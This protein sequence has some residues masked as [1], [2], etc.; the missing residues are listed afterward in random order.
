MSVLDD[1]LIRSSTLGGAD[2]VTRAEVTALVKVKPSADDPEQPMAGARVRLHRAADG[3]LAWQGRSGADGSYRASGLEAGTSYVPVAIDLTGTYEAV[4]AGPVLAKEPVRLVPAEMT[5]TVGQPFEQELRLTGL[6]PPV[7][8]IT[9][10]GALPSGVSAS[11]LVLSGAWPTGAVGSYPIIYSVTDAAGEHEA[12]GSIEL[13]LLPL[14][15]S[16][17]APVPTV[18]EEKTKIPDI[19][20]SATGGELPY[21]WACV[22]DLPTGVTFN[23][24]TQVLSGTPTI[25]DE[26]FDA[27]ISVTDVRGASKQIR[28]NGAVLSWLDGVT[29]YIR[30]TGDA[31]DTSF[32]DDGP[33]ARAIS[34]S[35]TITAVT[36]ADAPSGLAL[37]GFVGGTSHLY[38]SAVAAD[39]MRAGAFQLDFGIRNTAAIA[40]TDG[41]YTVLS[42]AENLSGRVYEWNIGTDKDAIHFYYGTRGAGQAHVRFIYPGG[43]DLSS[44][45]GTRHAMSIGRDA[46]GRWGAW[47]DGVRCAQYEASSYSGGISYGAR[48]TGIY[49]NSVD[50]GSTDLPT[51]RIGNFFTSLGATAARTL[52][53]LVYRVGRCRDVTT[54]YTV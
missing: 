38:V 16:T 40:V 18:F 45:T 33:L 31:D 24:S 51:L 47:V 46:S 13:V 20:F 14:V 6:T 49:T 42:L 8:A 35:G 37:S 41:V 21:T 29:L 52:D 4:A 36:D 50:I 34:S 19:V 3:W 9:R 22:G 11:S 15:V 48:T 1:K 27:T 39:N 54:D 32:V 44:T 7:T 10:S 25:A 12:L 23:T 43:L 53:E 28:L 17:S 5:A 2:I 30:P 26:D